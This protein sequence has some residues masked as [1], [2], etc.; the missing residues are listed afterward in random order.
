MKTVLGMAFRNCVVS[1]V[2]ILTVLGACGSLRGQSPLQVIGEPQ[3]IVQNGVCRFSLEGD[4]KIINQGPAESLS[5]SLRFS[6]AMTPN[7]FPDAGQLVSF[8]DIGQLEGGYEI[9]NAGSTEPI[10]IPPVTGF[11]FFTILLEEYT[12]S[13]WY[14]HYAGRSHVFYLEAGLA[15]TPPLWKPS[16]RRVI[17]PPVSKPTG[18]KLVFSRKA[19][20]LDGKV[21]LMPKVDQFSL[22]AKL[23][24]NGRTVVYPGG[25]TDGVGADWSYKS[26]KAKWHGKTRPV[27]TL[28]I[29]HGIQHGKS[30]K[31][32]Y[33]LFFQKGG[34][35][36]FKNT[37]VIGNE[38]YTVWGLFTLQ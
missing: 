20:Q 26:S 10:S 34:R 35:G 36:F 29:D 5:G 18:K 12:A 17:P 22:S 13:G 24:R 11:R 33:W 9:S 38:S 21:R 32:T 27:G 7:P 6:L 31:S 16:A 15:G 19:I 2:S 28:V 14:T 8:A 4:T 1:V 30:A 25:E 37:N 3:W 23:G